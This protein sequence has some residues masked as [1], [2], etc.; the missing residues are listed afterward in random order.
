MRKSIPVILNA[1]FLPDHH[2]AVLLQF[3]GKCRTIISPWGPKG[4]KNGKK[5]LLQS[6]RKHTYTYIHLLTNISQN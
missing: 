3:Y 2:I 1:V 5:N 6:V 4:T